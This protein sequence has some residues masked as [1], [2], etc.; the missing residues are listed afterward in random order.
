[1]ADLELSWSNPIESE[2]GT[3]EDKST[4]VI[5]SLGISTV[6]MDAKALKLN[7]ES[8]REVVD[9][10]GCSCIVLGLTQKGLVG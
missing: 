6:D 7:E 9:D 8:V 5:S 10:G 1:M 2:K 3:G 4:E